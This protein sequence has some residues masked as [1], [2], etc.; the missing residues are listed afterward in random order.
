MTVVSALTTIAQHA[1]AA[2]DASQMSI[3]RSTSIHTTPP[4]TVATFPAIIHVWDRSSFNQFPYGQTPT[5]FQSEEATIVVYILTNAPTM[6]RA[7]SQLLP[8][9]D[10]Y[11]TFIA[12]HQAL[13]DTVRQ[14]ILTSA[15]QEEVEYNGKS[16]YGATLTLDARIYHATTWVE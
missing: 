13:S 14:V 16:Y 3:V 1:K 10:A 11:R 15:T 4:E 7:Q 6:S 5:G 8:I 2:A 9:V 12:Q